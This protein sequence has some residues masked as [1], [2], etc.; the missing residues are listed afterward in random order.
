MNIQLSLKEL[1]FAVFPVYD[2]SLSPQR[3]AYQHYTSEN[4]T[5]LA[6]QVISE[7]LAK[8]IQ[9]L[10]PDEN[11]THIQRYE[12]EGVKPFH[13]LWLKDEWLTSSERRR[14]LFA[15][16]VKRVTAREPQDSLLNWLHT[17]A[18]SMHYAIGLDLPI[19]IAKIQLNWKMHEDPR[20]MLQWVMSVENL[21]GVKFWVEP[22]QNVEQKV[23]HKVET[24]EIQNPTPIQD[25]DLQDQSAQQ[26]A[27]D[28]EPEGGQD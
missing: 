4:S 11:F 13:V 9:A 16:R 12:L 23:E 25:P 1:I 10:D 14:L 22:P 15:E 3:I 2:E 19:C 24:H 8:Q 27:Q 17:L 20:R 26:E 5:G 7:H 21:F 6:R 18:K 28:P